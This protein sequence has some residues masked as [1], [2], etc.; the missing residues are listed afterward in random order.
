MSQ[1]AIEN[2]PEK[3]WTRFDSWK[4]LFNYSISHRR[5]VKVQLCLALRNDLETCDMRNF[6][7]SLLAQIF[8]HITSHKGERVPNMEIL[9]RRRTITTTSLNC[10]KRRFS[11]LA[12]R[13]SSQGY[14][15]KCEHWLRSSRCS[16]V[17]FTVRKID[18]LMFVSRVVNRKLSLA[19]I[20]Y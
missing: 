14:C 5:K 7:R 8:T 13:T 2:H 4:A 16:P 17:V 19:I 6:T 20:D 1:F 3:G 12:S 11:F 15:I 9:W 18:L 10:L